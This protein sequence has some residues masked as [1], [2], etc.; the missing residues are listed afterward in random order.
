MAIKRKLS[1]MLVPRPAESVHIHVPATS[2]EDDLIRGSEAF[3]NTVAELVR[4]RNELKRMNEQLN[5]KVVF[6]MKTNERLEQE[7]D[8]CR[9]QTAEY[10]RSNGELAATIGGMLALAER[11][12]QT[13]MLAQNISDAMTETKTAPQ[14]HATYDQNG[15]PLDTPAEVSLQDLQSLS[16]VLARSE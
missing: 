16:T 1:D 4:E 2:P 11:A 9:R 3:T 5:R 14:P 8:L 6:Y 10:I 15:M 12:S 13:A 7:R